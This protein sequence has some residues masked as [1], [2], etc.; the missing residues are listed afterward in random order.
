MEVT[1]ERDEIIGFVEQVE[2]T[3]IQQLHPDVVNALWETA[4][5]VSEDKRKFIME[6]M[7]LDVPDTYWQKF[8]DLLLRHHDVFS[9][10]K[11]DWDEPNTSCMKL[12]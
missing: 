9:E 10:N 3:D 1:L 7:N 5:K 8:V 12:L 11:Y 4:S 2:E 6:K